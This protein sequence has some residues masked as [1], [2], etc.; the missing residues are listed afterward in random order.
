VKLLRESKVYFTAS[1]NGTTP[2]HI[3]VK[4]NAFPIVKYF[5]EVMDVKVN[6]AKD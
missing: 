2:L 4:V 3:A 1:N 5:I 6:E